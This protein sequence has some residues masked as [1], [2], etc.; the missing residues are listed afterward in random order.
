MNRGDYRKDTSR[1]LPPL[2]HF[3]YLGRTYRWLH[4][5]TVHLGNNEKYYSFQASPV[6]QPGYTP[7]RQNK[8]VLVNTFALPTVLFLGPLIHPLPP[9]QRK[10]DRVLERCAQKI[11]KSGVNSCITS[12]F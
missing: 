1:F 6:E 4:I 11:A 8:T 12:I 5:K 7:E 9:V 2:Y 3:E 10:E